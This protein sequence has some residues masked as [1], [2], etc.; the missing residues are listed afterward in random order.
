MKLILFTLLIASIGTLNTAQACVYDS[1]NPEACSKKR[2]RKV[3]KKLKIEKAVL[4]E[5]CPLDKPV[6]KYCGAKS[7]REDIRELID[8]LIKEEFPELEY[9]NL[10][11]RFFKSDAY[12][13]ATWIKPFSIVRKPKNRGYIVK[14]NENLFDCPPPR[15]ALKAIMIHELQHI[16]DYYTMK[17]G[18]LI[19]LIASIGLSHK[20]RA[21][22]ER[23]TDLET[24][25]K[26][27]TKGLMEYRKWI[28]AKISGTDLLTKKLF[29]W[30]PCQMQEWLKIN[31]SKYPQKQ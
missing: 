12:Y 26:G 27:Y 11:I 4:E 17:S 25:K 14:I 30:T 19:N 3:S 18:K 15:A 28:Y 9:V 10:S 7:S 13:L 21:I 5:M 16:Y 29:Y 22:Y 20:E 6:Q 8:Q 1:D 24:M 2:V 31:S 23:N